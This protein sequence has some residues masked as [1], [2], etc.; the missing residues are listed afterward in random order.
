[1][2]LKRHDR[3]VIVESRPIL[4]NYSTRTHYFYY[5]LGLKCYL[6]NVFP[7]MNGISSPLSPFILM[8]ARDLHRQAAYSIC[9]S[10]FLIHQDVYHD[11]I[12]CVYD[13]SL[14]S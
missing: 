14:T 7:V 2:V 9:E 10:W 1:M 11:L 8:A 5:S 6:I 13:D 12:V 4:T 3:R